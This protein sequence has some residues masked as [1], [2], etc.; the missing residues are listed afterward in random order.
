ASLQTLC[1][2]GWFAAI[3]MVRRRS[4]PEPPAR[5]AA[6]LAVL[7]CGARLAFVQ[8]RA[9]APRDPRTLGGVAR[10][11]DTAEMLRERPEKV[12]KPE[13]AEKVE[14]GESKELADAVAEALSQAA[15][16]AGAAAAAAAASAGQSAQS[17]LQSRVDEAK[18]KLQAEINAIPVK[19]SAAAQEAVEQQKQKIAALPKQVGEKASEALERRKQTL[20]EEADAAVERAKQVPQEA[21]E[22][23]LQRLQKLPQAALDS[24]AQAGEAQAAA[25]QRSL[26]SGVDGALEA[27]QAPFFGFS[28]GDFPRAVQLRV[29][30]QK[31]VSL[32]F[33]FSWGGLFLVEGFR[34]SPRL[35]GNTWSARLPRP[36]A[37]QTAELVTKPVQA[38]YMTMLKQ[39][40]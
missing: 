40:T 20:K 19:I 23:A 9:A 30:S 15:L 33:F 3:A 14:K 32:F 4:D 8:P 26:Q 25:A 39:C 2:P 28:F 11:A 27:V 10:Y 22:K 31:P 21:L 7:V 36:H 38:V 12:E 29:S 6:V 17:A 5:R 37:M 35:L 18:G 16:S 24:L 13:T 1:A 34:G